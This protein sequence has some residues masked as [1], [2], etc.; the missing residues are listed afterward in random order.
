MA[1]SLPFFA[2]LALFKLMI[3][4]WFLFGFFI[5]IFL[6]LLIFFAW[7]GS[8][9][10]EERGNSS[11]GMSIS[12]YGNWNN[13]SAAV[14][15]HYGNLPVRPYHLLGSGISNNEED[16]Q[17]PSTSVPNNIATDP[18]VSPGL[19]LLHHHH[20]HAH[21]HLLGNHEEDSSTESNLLN[22]S[23]PAI[24]V[25][26]SNYFYSYRI[27][28]LHE[29]LVRDPGIDETTVITVSIQQELIIEDK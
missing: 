5:K 20:P 6:L 17:E 1:C 22:N 26:V 8:I 28:K 14:T 12:G 9:I 15:S 4:K 11:G 18:G 19:H 2:F 25:S 23:G 27:H 13:S 16:N 21:P 24:P 10:E 29:P 7:N 3:V